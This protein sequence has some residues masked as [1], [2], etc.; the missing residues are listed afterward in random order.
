MYEGAATSARLKQQ[1]NFG[2]RTFEGLEGEMVGLD[3]KFYLVKTDG[4]AYPI[5]DTVK[6]PFYVVTFF[7]IVDA[8]RSREFAPSLYS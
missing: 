5:T 6:T 2:L 3:G 4:V 1:G 8:L 7:P